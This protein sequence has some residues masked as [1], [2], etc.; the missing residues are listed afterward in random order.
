MSPESSSRP[1]GSHVDNELEMESVGLRIVPN[2]AKAEILCGML[3]DRNIGAPT[4][5]VTWQVPGLS[6]SRQVAQSRCLS[7][8]R[9]FLPPRSGSPTSDLNQVDDVAR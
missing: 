5:K 8:K 6:A 7:R 3:R 4:G 1:W 2:E 9:T